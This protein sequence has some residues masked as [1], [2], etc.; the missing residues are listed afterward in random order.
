MHCCASGV[1]QQ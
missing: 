1:E